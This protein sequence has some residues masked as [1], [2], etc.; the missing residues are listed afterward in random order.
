MNHDNHDTPHYEDSGI[1]QP[2]HLVRPSIWPLLGA[3]AA[4][5]MMGFMVMYMHK[6][7]IHLGSLTIYPGLKGALIGLA[8]VLV[9]MFVWWK[10]IIHEAF[11]EQ[12]HSPAVKHGLH[13]GMALFISS[14]VMFFVAFFW[15][16]Y[17]AAL[18]PP[19][20]LGG[21]W[22]P[23]NIHTSPTFDMPFFMTLILLLSGTTV[24]WAHHS[25]LTNNRKSLLCALAV[26]VALGLSFTTCQAYEYMNTDFGLKSGM[27]GSTFFMATGFHGLHVIIGTIFLAVCWWRAKEDQFTPDSHFGLTAAA[28]YWHFVDVVW[29]FLF[30]SIYWYGASP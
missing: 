13:Y 11:A 26:T 30:V 16:Y 3:L 22:P 2:W 21:I 24:T 17:S 15:A 6:D 23:A 20:I 7:K 27:F 12:A 29:L 14:E 25:V 19:A 4:G 8:G 10:D 28:W 1:P 5:I 9:V 18:F